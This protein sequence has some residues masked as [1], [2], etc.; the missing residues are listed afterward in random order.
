MSAGTLHF[1][2]AAP[3]DCAVVQ[4]MR[5]ALALRGAV[6]EVTVLPDDPGA[7]GKARLTCRARGLGV[8]VLHDAV[9]MLELVEDRF[10]DRPLHP[11]DP[12]VRARHRELIG[13]VLAAHGSLGAV[14]AA[15]DPRDLDLAVYRLRDRLRAIADGL[16]PVRPTQPFPLTNLALA[17]APLLWRLQVIDRNFGAMLG[18]GLPRLP[19][20]ADSLLVNPVVAT[21]LDGAAAARLVAR[22]QGGNMALGRIETSAL[23]DRAFVAARAKNKLLPAGQRTKVPSIGRPAALR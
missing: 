6:P 15:P 11:A 12:L 5:L 2:I 19:E 13:K 16:E 21:V 9:A 8:V 23:W 1:H 3:A 22:L 10:P 4:Q 7:A 14:L 20:V 18:L 17:L